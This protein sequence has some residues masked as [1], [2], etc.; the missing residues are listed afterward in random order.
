MNFKELATF[1]I[2]L[3]T[4]FVNHA[5]S[6]NS[7]DKDPNVVIIFIDDLGYADP[8][9]FGNTLVETPNIDALA[10]NGLVMTN[11]YVDSPI[12]SPSRTALLTGRYPMRNRIH[13]FIND[14]KNNKRRNMADFLDPDV[15][16]IAKA[17]QDNGYKTGH[18]GKWH[19]GGGRDVDYAPHI[20]EYGFDYSFT[21]FEGLG[22]RV[23]FKDH[24]LSKQSSELG[25]G[26][27]VWANKGEVTEMYVDSA[28]AFM[29]RTQ[30]QPFYLQFFPDDVHD[31]HIPKPGHQER[32]KDVTDNPFEQKF[33]AVL[34]EMDRQ[35]GR[36]LDQMRRMGKL[37]NTLVV[38]TSDNGPTDWER[39]YKRNNYPDGYDGKLYAPG[40][41]GL[42]FGRKWSLY[43][44]GIRMPFIVHWK[45]VIPE[46]K[47]DLQTIMS[48]KDLYPTICGIL[49]IDYPDNLDGIDKSE[50]WMGCPIADVPPL[51]W[52]YGSA[53]GGSIQPGKKEHRSPQLAMR[54]G[55]WKLL[56]NNDS[57]RIMLFNLEKDPGESVNLVDKKTAIAREMASALLDWRRSMPV[58]MK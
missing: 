40:F 24:A 2:L 54:D 34:V 51:F 14:S 12:C 57:T 48:A 20:S 32:F 39:Y 10:N 19:L 53:P 43:E 46:G 45:D 56:M 47:A 33:L 29:E 21:S 22:D 11:F 17:L 50:A 7:K 42:F 30:D 35:I 49:D 37:D 31:R 58:E 38:F 25:Q 36:L 9:C 44:G 5:K 6:Q 8:S 1:V 4:T 23:L 13:S 18:V 28:L 27:V 26:D 3:F 55:K 15:S 52:E 16:T 41:T